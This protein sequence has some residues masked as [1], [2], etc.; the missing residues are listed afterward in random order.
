MYLVDISGVYMVNQ[1]T[2][3]E[4]YNRRLATNLKTLRIV[5]NPT[6][7]EQRFHAV[8]TDKLFDAY[9]AALSAYHEIITSNI[10]ILK[11][12]IA[13]ITNLLTNHE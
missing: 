3:I 11:N 5:S 6:M 12:H 10:N 4:Q 7:S 1:H 13:D 2:I 9:Q 8:T